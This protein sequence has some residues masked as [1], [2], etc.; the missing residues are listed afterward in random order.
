LAKEAL[1][2]IDMLNDFTLPGAPLEVPD[3]RKILSSIKR[4]IELAHD[5][6]MPVI[7]L[8]DNHDP[9]DREFERFG[10][11]P[12]AVKGTKGRQVVDEIKPLPED[13]EV[14]KHTYSGFYHTNLK[15]TLDSL[16]VDAIRMTGCLTHI[17]ILFVS[18]ECVLLGYRTT[19]VS[20]AI[21][22]TSPELNDAS[23]K[24]MR[25]VGVIVI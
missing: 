22:D 13:I 21:A 19:V 2:I 7:Y 16:G 8:C 11:P 23:L 20:D 25:D 1:I 6:G 24:I 5:K 4:E 10:W 15:E 9:D 14:K 17:C 3:N 12:H 18:Y